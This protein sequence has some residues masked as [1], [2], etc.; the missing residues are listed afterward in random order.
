[1]KRTWFTILY[2]LLAAPALAQVPNAQ[3][4]V[5][6]C[7]AK[8]PE[9]FACMHHD[10][11]PCARDF[12]I[13]CARDMGGPWGVNG[14]RGNPRDLSMDVIAYRG[15]GTAVDVTAG[16]AP[17]EII[18][19]CGGCGAPGQRIVWNPG[20]GGPGDRGAW[21]DPF[22]VQPSSGGWGG[23]GGTP[24][25][26]PWESK[27]TEILVKMGQPSGALDPAYVTRVAEQLAFAF[28]GE[29]WGT[30]SA[31]PGRPVSGDVIAR[32][33]AGRLTGYRIVPPTMNPEAI[34][35]P[36]QNFIAVAPQNHLGSGGGGGTG[37]GGAGGGGS[38]GGQTVNLQPVLDELSR[39]R[40]QVSGVR[41]LVEQLHTKADA[42]VGNQIQA[43]Q[44][45]QSFD[46]RI[47][48]QVQELLARPTTPPEIE[49]PSFTGRVLS[50]R[51]IFTPCAA[52]TGRPCS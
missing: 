23:G 26:V 38:T 12:V 24:G 19:I 28:P 31:A 43:T 30:K 20:P 15:A 11:Q 33:A 29:G 21:V 13:L 9:A 37:G 16:N 17:M 4:Q 42:V 49:W 14:K 39:L 35:L 18:D 34:D 6:A 32:Q 51:V 46:D 22:S 10:G 3:A 44:Q 1:M 45:L 5:E 48:A 52:T 41:S 47:S 2:L 36:G 7:A 27:H 25:A 40:D 8:Y 50:Q